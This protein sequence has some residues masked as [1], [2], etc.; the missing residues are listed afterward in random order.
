MAT[1]SKA[2]PNPEL[3]KLLI[4]QIPA[5]FAD[6]LDFV[7]IGA[8]LAFVWDA[9]PFV[10]ALL[11]VS[12]GLPYLLV[13]PFAGVFVDRADTRIVMIWSN[14]GR[15]IVTASFFVAPNWFILLAL[16][17]T[18]SSIDT[19]FTPSKQAAIQ[20][21]TATENRA[22][23]NGLS[24]AIN[25]SSKI[26]APA[27]GGGLLI[28]LTPQLVFLLNAGVSIMAA[29]LLLRLRPLTAAK[30]NE[31]LKAVGMLETLKQGLDEI[32]TKIVL[33]SAIGMMAAGYFAMFFYDTLIAPLTRDLGYTQTHLGLSLAAVGAGGVLG[34]VLLSLAKEMKRPFVAIALG[35]LVSGVTVICLGAAEMMNLEIEVAVFIAAFGVLGM[36]SAFSVVPFR[37]IVQ[38]SVSGSSIG[39]IT[40]LSEAT[41]T[42]ALLT[43]PFIGAL[44]ASITS[45][46][47]AFVCGGLVMVLVSAR[48]AAL[49]HHR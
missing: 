23:A 5:D 44:I 14:I 12:M 26:V 28:W 21:L 36:S 19:F 49:R 45:I 17:V 48:A 4:A 20:A 15:A 18:R 6:W 42:A 31:S 29:L 30:G 34:A 2:K 24:H 39:R 41:N 38:N 25:Q 8:L 10:F 3:R 11:A 33:R 35:S 7:A 43:A 9:E 40:A 37:T 22:R 32:R 27:V 1:T 47:A 13:G 16:I 46:G